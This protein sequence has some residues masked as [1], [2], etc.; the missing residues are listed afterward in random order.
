MLDLLD[1]DIED[2]DQR[3]DF[4]DEQINLSPLALSPVVQAV[5]VEEDGTEVP[6][7][8]EDT[9]PLLP[10]DYLPLSEFPSEKSFQQL[11]SRKYFRIREHT[12]KTRG[13]Y[14]G[15]KALGALFNPETIDYG[16]E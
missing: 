1:F 7:S 8:E 14:K 11:L 2:R 9:V 4:T 6:H 5:E 10:L 13:L 15:G 12:E 3:V 16:G